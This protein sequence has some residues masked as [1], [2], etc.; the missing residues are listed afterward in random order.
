[1]RIVHRVGEPG[2]P[3]FKY[4][5]VTRDWLEQ[6]SG[7]KRGASPSYYG[8]LPVEIAN[9]E[10]IVRAVNCHA[11]LIAALKLAIDECQSV[12]NSIANTTA[13]DQQMDALAFLV[14]ALKKT[15]QKAEVPS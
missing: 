12:A 1:M 2:Q 15:L 4:R 8:F 6:K 3:G 7:A 5:H 13:N 9:A 14:I 11:D 10:L